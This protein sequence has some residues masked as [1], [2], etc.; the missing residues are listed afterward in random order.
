MDEGD[1]LNLLLFEVLG[2]FSSISYRVDHTPKHGYSDVNTD[3]PIPN[4]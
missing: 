1:V 2:V 4:R 3:E